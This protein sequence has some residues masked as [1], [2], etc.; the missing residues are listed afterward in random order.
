MT[1]RIQL[2]ISTMLLVVFKEVTACHCGKSPKEKVDFEEECEIL[3][4]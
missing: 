2:T 3:G 4:H 1:M